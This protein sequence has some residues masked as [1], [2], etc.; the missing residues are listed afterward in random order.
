MKLICIAVLFLALCLPVI[1]DP[2]IAMSSEDFLDHLGVNT[3]LNGLTA[4][5][6]WNTN[7]KQV[8]E[9]LTYIG[10]RLDRD[11]AWSAASGP[12]W[13]SVQDGWKNG[14]FWT[15]IDEGSPADQRKNL[16]IEENIAESFPRLIYAMG[17]PNEEDND[18]AQKL[19]STL[20]DSAL[21][22]QQ[23]YDWAHPKGI[24]VSQMEFGSGWTTSNNWEGDYNP[25]NTGL[26]QNY[27]P[28]PA[29]FGGAHTYLSDPNQTP[30]TIL[31]Q[32]RKDA[33]LCSP[34]KLVAHTEM[35]GYYRAN[36]TLQGYG[37]YMVLGAFDSAAAGDAADIIYGLQDSGPEQTYGFFTYPA[38]I[39]NPVADYFHTMTTLL[40]SDSMTYARGDK[41]TFETYSLNVAYS[42]AKGSHLLLEKPSKAVIIAD[43]SEQPMG[44]G[45]HVETD[46]ITFGRS[47]KNVDVYDIER[48]L[49]PLV[50]LHDVSQCNLILD[51][52]DVY[53][54][55][56]K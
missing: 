44:S 8:A 43:W 52:N 48:G 22:Q 7:A 36:L 49:N 30:I 42:N 11:W 16:L 50:S 51:P 35:G 5:D 4:A 17:G 56:L 21:V 34:G 25:T 1:A 9:Q 46:T 20:P 18:F 24:L 27:V 53:L 10:V 45:Q 15:S 41:P 38:G 47:F 26:K 29:D 19:G 14:R 31:N 6:P 32:L 55:I 33:N 2:T 28:G 37:Q 12:V 40:G 23:L 39:S 54:V 13:K 3:H